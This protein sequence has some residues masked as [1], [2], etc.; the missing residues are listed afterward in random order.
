MGKEFNLSSCSSDDIG[1][2]V[3]IQHCGWDVNSHAKPTITIK[4]IKLIAK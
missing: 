3:A 4:S 2:G 1:Y